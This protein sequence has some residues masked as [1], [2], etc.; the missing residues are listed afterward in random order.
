MIF[1]SSSPLLSPACLSSVLTRLQLGIR[2]TRTGHEFVAWHGS[3][4]WCVNNRGPNNTFGAP[5]LLSTLR[6]NTPEL[7]AQQGMGLEEGEREE[8]KE[9]T[10]RAKEKEER[11][12]MVSSISP[13]SVA[14]FKQCPQLFYYRYE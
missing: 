13:S 10:E 9:R 7:A 1:F 2:A 4:P 3:T 5:A 6:T 8:G 12:T 11:T 14:A